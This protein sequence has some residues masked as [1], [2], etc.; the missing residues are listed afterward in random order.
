MHDKMVLQSTGQISLSNVAV[1]FNDT[2]KP[3]KLSEFY[4]GGGLVSSS[5]TGIPISGTI[6]L[7][8]FFGKALVATTSYSLDSLSASA[9]S[10][11]KG[12]YAFKK[13]YSGYSGPIFAVRR[14][15][16]ATNS[17]YADSTGNLYDATNQTFS[18]WASSSTVYITTWYDQSGLNN[19][20]TQTNTT[21]QPILTYSTKSI[22][23]RTGRFFN[24]PNG[25]I[26][27]G[28][29]NYTIILK[30]GAISA[31]RGTIFGSGTYNTNNAVVALEK[32]STIYNHYWWAND[33]AFGTFTANN[34]VSLT[35]DTTAGR[36]NYIN[37][38]LSSSSTATNRNSTNLNNTIGTDLRV[39]ST[40]GN[41][42]NGDLFNIVVFSTVLSTAD[43]N[44]CE[45]I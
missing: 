40:S 5:I 41:A 29:T 12:L 7:Y 21:Y 33:T 31:S 20:A 42:M 25:T 22:D 3:Y 9:K 45:A 8:N 15:D 18:T 43:R 4:A 34:V 30:H 27:F 28:N 11:M 37:G 32:D 17:F 16:N 24:M 14:S 6:S 13:I 23:F 36:K 38:T 26:P 1:E 2:L 19:N 10:G 44:I 35:Y 39:S